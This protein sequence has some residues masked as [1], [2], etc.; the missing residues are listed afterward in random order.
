MP[1]GLNNSPATFRRLVLLLL[2][3]YDL[4]DLVEH[5]C[6]WGS[7]VEICELIQ[8]HFDVELEGW[9]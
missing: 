6:D 1:F 2:L 4:F 3:V 7:H 9:S 5:S 8:V